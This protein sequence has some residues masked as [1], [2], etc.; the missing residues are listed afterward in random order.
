[1]S[2]QLPEVAT[3]TARER[4]VGGSGEGG[5]FAVAGAAIRPSPL[6]GARSSPSIHPARL[7]PTVLCRVVTGLTGPTL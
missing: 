7:R 6:A 1:M 5:S 3:L 4:S 2:S